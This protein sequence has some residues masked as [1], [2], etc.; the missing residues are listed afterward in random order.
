MKLLVHVRMTYERKQYFDLRISRILN[1]SDC[2]NLLIFDLQA[3]RP[4]S[5]LSP[6]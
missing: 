5:H 4:I 3:K 2:V 6:Y 1:Y